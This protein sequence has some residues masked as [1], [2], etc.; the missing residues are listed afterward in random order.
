MSTS[1]EKFVVTGANLKQEWDQILQQ[2]YLAKDPAA[3]SEEGRILD[4]GSE[5]IRFFCVYAIGS[6]VVP[7]QN[8]LIQ[9]EADGRRL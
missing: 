9:A 6:S 1:I 2:I 3:P 4:V 8:R 5:I 7:I